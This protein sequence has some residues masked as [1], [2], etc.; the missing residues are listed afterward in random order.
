MRNKKVIILIVLSIIAAMSIVYGVTA[1]RP[2]RQGKN[3]RD[4]R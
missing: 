1:S 3:C 2:K 4:Y